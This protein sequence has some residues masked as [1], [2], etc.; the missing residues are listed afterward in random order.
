MSTTTALATQW[1]NP[2]D[3]FSLL[4]LLGGDVVQ[5][6]IAQLVGVRFHLFKRSIRITPVAFSFGWAAFAF[7]ALI[8]TVGINRLMPQP[9]TPLIV[10][11]CENGIARSN[12][13]WV[14]DR[15]MR[16]YEAR[17]EAKMENEAPYH[18]QGKR[19]GV[20]LRV[21]IYKAKA[22]AE[23]QGPRI[24]FTWVTGCMVIVIQQVLAAVPWIVWG[25]WGIFLVTI[26]GTFIC[27]ITAGLPQWTAEKWPAPCIDE[28]KKKLIALTRGNGTQFVMIV[29]C[30]TGAWDLEAM[31]SSRSAVH[32]ETRWFTFAFSILWTILLITVTALKDHT[33]FLIAIG[34]LGMLQNALAAGFQL[35][36]EHSNIY[37]EPC[38]PIT[39]YRA[40]RAAKLEAAQHDD[41]NSDEEHDQTR[42]FDPINGADV[43]DVMGTLIQLEKLYPGAGG[44]LIPIYFPGSQK[45]EA[46]RMK[47]NKDKKFWK[48]AYRTMKKR[49]SDMGGKFS[50]N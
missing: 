22:I 33:W 45:Y 18:S 27:L 13:S 28:G 34:G 8:G 39:G 16:D 5:K 15:L 43:A 32:P 24:D 31:A 25:D 1:D 20:S 2:S 35:R 6:A 46:M 3:I 19:R 44:S 23:H 11:N 7:L 21:D 42:L 47:F 10:I 40:D 4:L 9:E 50:S 30:E 12:S 36:P 49:R 41:S 37:L 26:S 29:I 38:E 48:S 17:L 14:L